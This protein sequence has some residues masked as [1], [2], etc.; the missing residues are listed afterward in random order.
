MMINHIMCAS[1]VLTDLCFTK[2]KIK[3]KKWF[4]RSCLQCLSSESVLIKHKENCLSINGKQSVKVEKGMIEFGNYFKQ[5]PYPFKI[6]ADF[7]CNVRGV[8]SYE[9]SYTK[10]YQDHIPCSFAYK[11]VCVDDRFAKTIVVYRGENA[12]YEFIKAI[13]KEYKYCR[14]VMSKH[15]NENLIMSEEEEQLLDL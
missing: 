2:Q 1:K 4:C 13:L 3:T 10:R 15:F 9:G 6:Y 12:A 5:I 11:V 8:E 14:K 7:E